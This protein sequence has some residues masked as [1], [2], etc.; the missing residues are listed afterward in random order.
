[1]THRYGDGIEYAHHAKRD[2]S[3]PV[4]VELTNRR[5][6][7]LVVEWVTRKQRWDGMLSLADDDLIASL[8]EIG[9]LEPKT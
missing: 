3:C 8:R 6:R 4:C 7:E 5:L 1:M 9:V 2:P